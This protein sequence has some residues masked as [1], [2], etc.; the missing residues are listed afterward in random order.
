MVQIEESI[1]TKK[2]KLK[3]K[4]QKNFGKPFIIKNK[5]LIPTDDYLELP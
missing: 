1:F 4:Y 5:E 3:K 2:G